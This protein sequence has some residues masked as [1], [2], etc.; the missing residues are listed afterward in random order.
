MKTNTPTNESI[1]R[2]LAMYMETVSPP[3]GGLEH[4][5]RE[6]PEHVKYSNLPRRAIRSP[7][8][9]LGISQLAS[10]CFLVAIMVPGVIRHPADM[11]YFQAIDIQ[12]EQFES[13]INEMDYQSM[14]VQ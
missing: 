14:L 13:G 5:L 10:L 8:I 7:Y 12:V 3:R 2:A 4:I 11:D 6:L 1:E 9:W